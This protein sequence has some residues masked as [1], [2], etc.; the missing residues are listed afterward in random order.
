MNAEALGYLE[1]L[2]WSKKAWGTLQSWVAEG[3]E[4]D[5]EEH[6]VSVKFFL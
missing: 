1:N 5:L 2:P 6:A 3:S 4:Q